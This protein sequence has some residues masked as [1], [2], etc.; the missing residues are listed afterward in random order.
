MLKRFVDGFLAFLLCLML[1]FIIS[2]LVEL[3]LE[4]MEPLTKVQSIAIRKTEKPLLFYR[5][6]DGTLIPIEEGMPQPDTADA[7][8]RR[9]RE[10]NARRKARGLAPVE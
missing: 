1:G 8:T 10:M 2:R 7:R 9:L 5:W 3:T 4:R 6:H